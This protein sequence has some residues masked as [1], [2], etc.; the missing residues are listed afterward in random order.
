MF[1]MQQRHTHITLL[2]LLLLAAA[3]PA[4]GENMSVSAVTVSTPS[5]GRDH[6]LV[7]FNL[8]WRNSWRTASLPGN[9][10]AAWVFVKFRAHD[11]VWR[12]ATLSTDPAHHLVRHDNRVPARVEIGRTDGRGV[13][14]FLSRARDGRGTVSWRGV[15]LRWLRSADGVA[16][17]APVEVRVFALEMVHVPRGE[18]AVGDGSRTLVQ[19]QLHRSGIVTQPFV[20][21]QRSTAAP[22]S[23]GGVSDDALA[24]NDAVGMF[25]G[26]ED[27]FSSIAVQTLP[28]EFPKGYDGFYSM[29][30]EITEREYVDFLNTLTP[31]QQAQR[32]Y[33]S[34]ENG[35]EI[36]QRGDVYVTAVPDQACSNLNWADGTAYCD[37]AGLRP[38]TE[39]EFEK[40]C[41][42]PGLPMPNAFAWGDTTL[43]SSMGGFG[44]PFA[45]ADV[46]TDDLDGQRRGG[47]PRHEDPGVVKAARAAGAPLGPS[48]FG[49]SYWG[50]MDLSG[51]LWERCVSIGHPAGRAFTGLPGDGMLDAQGNAD[52]VGWPGVDSIG[53]GFRGGAIFDKIAARRVSDRYYANYASD[54]RYGNSGFRGVR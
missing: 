54:Y 11:G 24:N 8:S 20:I 10:D 27:D 35:N 39:M 16:P 5:G 3:Q 21:D 47:G 15:T 36:R 48:S 14:V 37:W 32:A 44:N 41:R 34:G 29:K 23:L 46:E 9:H 40:A 17:E 38:M 43:P 7:H 53:A 30:Y 2:A 28:P 1:T 18:F 19:G 12:H 42:G 22:I 13:G 33:T 26:N 51:R 25:T 45:T 49:A 6:A 50:I 4:R 31:A 52:V